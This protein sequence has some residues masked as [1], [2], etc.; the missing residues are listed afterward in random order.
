VDFGQVNPMRHEDD[1]LAPH[2]VTSRDLKSN[3]DCA[4]PAH[5]LSQEEQDES[6]EDGGIA[7]VKIGPGQRLKLK[8]AARMAISR[9]HAK[10]CQVAV[11]TYRFWSAI[12]TTNDEVC[13]TLSMEQKA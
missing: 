10:W 2:T 6:Q 1:V 3:N 9:E 12:I 11:A 7:I 5:F 8:T 4:A 13:N